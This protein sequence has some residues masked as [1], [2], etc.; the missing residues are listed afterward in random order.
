MDFKTPPLWVK[1]TKF[2]SNRYRLLLITPEM[3]FS[4]SGFQKDVSSGKY[5]ILNQQ[6][7]N[8]KQNFS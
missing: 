1:I 3:G 7:K 2:T 5:C 6:Q 8:E 4:K